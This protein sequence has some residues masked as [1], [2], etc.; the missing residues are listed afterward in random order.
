MRIGL[1]ARVLG[2]HKTGDRSYLL[3]LVQGF[4]SLPGDHQF[5]LYFDQPPPELNLPPQ[6]EI[7]VAPAA[8][9]R[10]WTPFVLPRVAR[11]DGVDVLQVQ[12]IAPGCRHPR[13][14]TTIHDVTYRLHPEWFP[15]K[16]RVLLD[17]GIR[18]SLSTVAGVITGSECT[19]RDLG[20]V[21]GLAPERI[22]VT[23]YAA[24]VGF[25]RASS[26]QV[27]EVLQHHGLTQPYVLFVG[28][29][30]PRKNLVR[31]LRAFLKAKRDSGFPHRLAVVG[32]LGWKSTE[33]ERE[34]EAAEATGA[35]QRLGYVPDEDLPPLFTGAEAFLFP[36]LYEG[37]G[38]PV[39][40]AFACGVPVITSDV[41]ALPEVAGDA[42][43]LVDPTD[44]ATLV[45]ALQRVLSDPSLRT[46]LGEAGLQ[47]AATFTWTRT[48]QQTLA[49][50]EQLLS[51]DG[52]PTTSN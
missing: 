26:E 16:D 51:E 34:M 1:D 50:Y 49:Y 7:R 17:L 19:R 46:R 4:A 3:G 31:I 40:E 20:Q 6:F 52:H 36:T 14:V 32:K 41:S 18:R 8:H 44:E 12:Y 24:P 22:A 10:L 47:R 5:L 39:L 42:A 28:V 29:L 35:V 27:S 9:P 38:I 45:D 23:P 37:F 11:E 25:A 15:F 33:I 48:A 2:A 30:Q 21:Y 43:V 13:V